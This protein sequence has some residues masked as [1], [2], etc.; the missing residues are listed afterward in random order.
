ML[1]SF[2]VNTL[3]LLH[4]SKHFFHSFAKALSRKWQ[5]FP[6]ISDIAMTNAIDLEVAGPYSVSKAAANMV[7]AKYNAAYKKEGVLFLSISPG[8]V[9]TE[10]NSEAA[11]SNFPSTEVSGAHSDIVV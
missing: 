5:T 10:R 1:D 11:E 8:Y 3:G 9:T 2:K 7:I 4:S 6:G